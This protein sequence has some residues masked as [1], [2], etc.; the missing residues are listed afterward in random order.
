MTGLMTITEALELIEVV[1]ETE[2]D[3]VSVGGSGGL[4]EVTL[5][6]TTVD[7][8]MADIEGYL[9]FTRTIDGDSFTVT[10]DTIEE[11]PDVDAVRITIRTMGGRS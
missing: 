6:G 9:S 3:L 10:R 5:F 1:F 7:A 8:A 11:A 4:V 2:P